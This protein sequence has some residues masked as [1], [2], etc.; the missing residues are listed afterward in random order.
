M[1]RG[2][3]SLFQLAS[4][5]KKVGNIWHLRVYILQCVGECVQAVGAY[6]SDD[7]GLFSFVLLRLPEQ[8]TV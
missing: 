5:P 8:W 3:G 1:F 6:W 7:S 4:N 2:A